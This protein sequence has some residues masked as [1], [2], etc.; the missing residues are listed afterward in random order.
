MQKVQR[1]G[2]TRFILDLSQALVQGL[3]PNYQLVLILQP[4]LFQAQTYPLKDILQVMSALQAPQMNKTFREH[5]VPLG[6]FL[7]AELQE[8]SLI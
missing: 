1:A 7:V 6:A 3:V 4:W 8:I 2:T 5:L